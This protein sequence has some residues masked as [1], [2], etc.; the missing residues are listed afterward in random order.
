MRF[1]GACCLAF[2]IANPTLLQGDKV[3]NL[4]DY[5][6]IADE[7]LAMSGILNEMPPEVSCTSERADN[8][9]RKRRTAVSHTDTRP[10]AI[11]RS[12]TRSWRIF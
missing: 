1:C 3:K 12:L 8:H 2:H 9:N 7:M 10:P 4:K 11:D 5:P 6:F